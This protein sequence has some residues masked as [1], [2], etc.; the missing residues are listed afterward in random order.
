MSSGGI[1]RTGLHKPLEDAADEI[2]RQHLS[3]IKRSADKSDV[4]TPWKHH[5]RTRREVYVSEGVPDG[6]LRRGIFSRGYNTA[7]PH[8]NS[9]EGQR[10]AKDTGGAWDRE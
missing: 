6:S 3:Q 10:P 9:V 4:L 5:D 1:I 2:L 7:H 8:L